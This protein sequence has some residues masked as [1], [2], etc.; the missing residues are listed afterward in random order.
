MFKKWREA[1]N[2]WK[3]VDLVVAL[4]AFTIGGNVRLAVVVHVVSPMFASACKVNRSLADEPGV[5]AGIFGVLL[6][7]AFMHFTCA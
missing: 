3:V 6:E 5:L 4:D 1:V 2:P 7:V